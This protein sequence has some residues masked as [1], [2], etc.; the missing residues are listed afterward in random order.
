MR[1]G[2]AAADRR[3]PRRTAG[4]GGARDPEQLAADPGARAELRDDRPDD[5][6]R[7]DARGDDASS[8]PTSGRRYAERD[9]AFA[10]ELAARA[11]TAIENARLYSERSEVAQTLQASL[12]PEELPAVPGWRLRRRLPPRPARRRGGRRLLRRLRRR[13]RARGRAR[14]RH[15]Q[16]R[17]RG[18]ADLARPLHGAHRR[19]FDARPSA[20]LAQVN[21]ALRQRP[22][23]APVT[24]VCGLL[25]GGRADAR[26]RRPPAAAAQARGRVEK[27]R[28]DGDAARRGAR[29]RAARPT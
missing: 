28:H 20:V 15:R 25:R 5:H 11:A 7:P 23:L 26:R 14:R 6:R 17:A 27:R 1:S 3:D 21:R 4:R 19:A 22:R 13:G 10:Q 12:L 24:M 29:L 16:G 18:G 9:L 8:S 2:R